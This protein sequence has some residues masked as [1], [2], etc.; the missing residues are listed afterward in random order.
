MVDL[1]GELVWNFLPKVNLLSQGGVIFAKNDYDD[2][3]RGTGEEEHNTRGQVR[4]FWLA[5]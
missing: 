1:I 3:S 2:G 4:N 5:I